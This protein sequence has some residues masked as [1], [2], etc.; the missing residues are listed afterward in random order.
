MRVVIFDMDGTLINSAKA[1]EITINTT[2]KKLGLTPD[3]SSEF[4]VKTINDPSKNYA[5][6]FYGLTNVAPELKMEFE[7]EFIKNYA[8][9]AR[10]YDGVKELLEKLHQNGY[11]IALASNAP[12]VSLKAILEKNKVLELFDSVVGA[13]KNTPQKPDPTMLFNVLKEASKI[14]PVKYACFVGDS[15]KDEKAATNANIPYLQVTWGFAEA[16]TSFLSASSTKEAYE[17]I[18]NLFYDN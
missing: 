7:K 14:R 6:E 9:Y 17:L 1:I 12:T 15:I 8:L 13:D 3:L 16:S 5:V 10:L 2:R 18:T 11:F 4:I